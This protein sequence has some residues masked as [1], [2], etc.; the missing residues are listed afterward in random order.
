MYKTD[1]SCPTTLMFLPY[2]DYLPQEESKG[3]KEK[4]RLRK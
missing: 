4:G 2:Y 1:N 3:K